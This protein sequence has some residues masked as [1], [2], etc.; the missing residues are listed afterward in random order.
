MIESK[1]RNASQNLIWLAFERDADRRNGCFLIGEAR[2]LFLSGVLDGVGLFSVQ[3]RGEDLA[4][5]QVVE[6][7]VVIHGSLPLP[8]F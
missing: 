7:L 3:C 8:T 1:Y 5:L 4:L 6:T 2:F